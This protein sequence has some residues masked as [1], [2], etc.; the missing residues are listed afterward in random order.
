MALRLDP[1][2]RADLVEGVYK[3]LLDSISSGSLG[4]DTRI[5]QE[6]IAAQ[7]GVSRSPVLQALRL[8]KKDGFIQDAP[9]RGVQAAPLEVER[10]RQLYEVR[11]ALDALAARLAAERHASIDPN[12]IAKGRRV[13]QGSNIN[14]AIEADI[15]FHEAIYQASGNPLIAETGRLHWAHLRRVMGAV[16]RSSGHRGTIWDEHEAIARAITRGDGARAA[17]LSEAHTRKASAHLSTQLDTLLGQMR[18]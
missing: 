13:V 14:A 7:L 11:G 17:E 8:L 1:L 12:L 2:P 5:T 4:P 16:L 18:K 10:T 15:A 6:E 9:N 3:V